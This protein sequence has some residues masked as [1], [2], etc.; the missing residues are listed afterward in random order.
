MRSLDS[1]PRLA[2]LPL[3]AARHTASLAL[4][5]ARTLAG[6]LVGQRSDDRE[7]GRE[8]TWEPP[9]ARPAGE[10]PPARAARPRPAAAPQPPAAAAPAAEPAVAAPPEPEP[11]HVDRD[12]VV[13]AEFAD[14]GAAD[15][16]GAN[17][18]VDEPWSGYDRLNARDVAAQLATADA[19]Q[20]AVVQLYESTHRKRRTVLKEIDR[21][22]ASV[23]R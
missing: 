5:V 12:A 22:L 4:S 20:L 16:A 1:L 2:E 21:R 9:S 11:L 18:H 6:P 15:G 10:P 14:T 3:R 8:R 19:A 7:N 17:V 13:V 23:A